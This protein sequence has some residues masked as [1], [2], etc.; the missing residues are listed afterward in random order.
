MI[1]LAE[2]I[3]FDGVAGTGRTQP[4]LVE[5]ETPDGV[6]HE[7]YLKASASPGPGVTGLANE[8]LAAAV[9]G[10]LGLPINEPFLVRMAE[11]WVR[12]I[13]DRAIR[14][15]LL[16]SEPVAFASKSAG[17]QWKAWARSDGLN[18]VSRPLALAVV[19]FDACI[20]NRD[21]RPDKPNCLVRGDQF[22]IID[23]EL[24]F[25]MHGLIGQKPEPWCSGY[26]GWLTSNPGHLFGSPLRGKEL[27]LDPIRASWE[28]LSDAKIE[29][30]L[31][32][33]PTEWRAANDAM[34]AAASHLRMA[35]IRLDDWLRELGRALT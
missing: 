4:L 28:L 19:A 32:W 27:N 9:A 6:M 31:T 11:D 7:A 26:L 22:R 3:R 29:Q 12:S 17:S 10:E 25:Y 21:R 13:P 33:L 20:E 34:A 2:A 24:A 1:R 15:R 8:A 23:H 30:F 16:K 14:E 5:V 18:L 35:R